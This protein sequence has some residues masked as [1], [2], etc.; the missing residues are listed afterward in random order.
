M[1]FLDT[2]FELD[3]CVL[4]SIKRYC[5]DDKT[6]RLSLGMDEIPLLFRLRCRKDNKPLRLSLF[7]LFCNELSCKSN[8]IREFMV[9]QVLGFIPSI[10]LLRKYNAFKEIEISKTRV[11]LLFSTHIERRLLNL[12]SAP[13]A[14]FCRWLL[15]KLRL[16]RVGIVPKV[17][18]LISIKLLKLKSNRRRESN[19]WKTPSK[20][21]LSLLCDRSIVCNSY[22]FGNVFF[23]ISVISLHDTF[24]NLSPVIF[25]SGT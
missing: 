10:R 24:S 5:N 3:V 11:R 19:V 22:N 7:R 15:F 20:I 2:R 21:W 14:T 25:P 1:Q 18:D 12:V 13:L 23:G 6:E 8:S 16:S 9:G 4:T 17:D